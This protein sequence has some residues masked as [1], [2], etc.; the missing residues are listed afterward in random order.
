MAVTGTAYPS[1]TSP[2][3]TALQ[4]R[5]Q[6]AA[7]MAGAT[8][9]RPLGGITGV[10][11]GTPVTTIG[12]VSQTVWSIATPFSG[13]IDLEGSTTNSGYFFTVPVN[14]AAGAIAAAAGS[15]RVDLIY[16]QI[17]DPNTG[18]GSGGT[19]RVTVD[20]Q[21]GVPGAGVPA[22][23]AARAFVISQINV[24]IS[25]GGLP[26]V[27]W[28][29]NVTAAAGATRVFETLIQLNANAG[30]RTGESAVVQND[31]TAT[32][33]LT[34][35]WNGT[36]WRSWASDVFTYTPTLTGLTLAGAG[37][38][39]GRYWWV[40][41]RIHLTMSIKFGGAGASLTGTVSFSLPV[42]AVAVD[43]SP[44]IEGNADLYHTS[45]GLVYDMRVYRSGITAMIFGYISYSSGSSL[46]VLTATGVGLPI[47]Y[48]NDDQFRIAELVY[49]PA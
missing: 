29:A 18:D 37:S 31:S 8:A 19:P 17:N 30:L 4:G 9:A 5:N 43:R 35:R 49:D 46:P 32:N 33:N 39:V 41:G 48:N 16:G 45:G 22:L 3:F 44:Q 40:N 13:Y 42:N 36:V 6:F 15:V 24:P 21:T 2:T 28:V 26:T 47:T 11:P 27:T 38:A 1:D 7:A 20:I 14:A 12:I 10:R 25:G 34:Y 23:T